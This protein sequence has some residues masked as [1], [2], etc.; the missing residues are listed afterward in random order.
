M[1]TRT[2]VLTPWYIP[3]RIVSWQDAITMMYLTKA[4]LVVPYGEEVRSPSVSMPM[5]AVIR[6]KRKVT[7]ARSRIR[8]SRINV[9]MRDGFRCQ[10]CGA[11]GTYGSLTFDHVV[12]RSQGGRTEWNNILTACG[13]CNSKKGSR[14]PTQAGMKP[15]RSPHAPK[16]LPLRDTALELGRIPEEWRD[17]CG[18]PAGA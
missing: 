8:F 1:A 16:S 11:R 9:F 10:Y 12:P 18:E 6:V 3:Y 5:P 17:F 13:S 4:D 2:L 15:L 14:T 7:V